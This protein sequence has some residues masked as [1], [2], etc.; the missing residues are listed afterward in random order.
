MTQSESLSLFQALQ[1]IADDETSVGESSS[2]LASAKNNQ[3]VT[4]SDQICLKPLAVGALI[5][6]FQFLDTG[7]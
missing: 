7:T 2:E 3:V 4:D 5:G 6:K 1:V